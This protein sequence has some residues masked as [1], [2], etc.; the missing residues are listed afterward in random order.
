MST[1]TDEYIGLTLPL[2]AHVDKGPF[3]YY[4]QSGMYVKI[5]TSIDPYNRVKQLARGGKA[6]R[7]VIWVGEPQL[8]A[9]EF[10][11]AFNERMRHQQFA[12]YRDVGEWFLLSE[13]LAEFIEEVQQAQTL[14]E[15]ALATHPTFEEMPFEMRAEEYQRLTLQKPSIDYGWVEEAKSF[16]A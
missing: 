7:P 9:V 16:I 4:I 10:G 15:L 8:L 3:V 13:E 11:S 12:K 5:G 2:E 14:Q 1:D 6:K